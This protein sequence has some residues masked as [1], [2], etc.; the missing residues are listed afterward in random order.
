MLRK[1]LYLLGILALLLI[2]IYAKE[3]GQEY[4][5]NGPMQLATEYPPPNEA[6]AIQSVVS[7][8]KI[9]LDKE[10]PEGTRMLRDAHPKQHGLLKAEFII[11]KNLPDHL[12]V[13]SK[14]S[15]VT[16]F[17]THP[18]LAVLFLKVRYQI[19]DLFDV[20]WGSTTP[21]LYG[22]KAVKYAILPQQKSDIEIPS[23]PSENYLRDRMS[24][25]LS[26]K[27]VM[28]DFFIQIQKDPEAMP[29]ED[30]RVRWDRALSPYLKVATIK[31]KSLSQKVGQI[32]STNTINN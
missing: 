24:A 6:E 17:L 7:S 22:D 9:L 12:K 18:S 29:I 13:E 23:N 25:M 10:Y 30:P 26:E 31:N 21:Y 4:T 11:E 27:D 15:A 8:L 1:L 14:L 32:L 16:H 28:L 19:A 5:Y 2:L 3:K 20:E